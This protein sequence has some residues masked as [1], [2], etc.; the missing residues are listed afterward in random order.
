MGR[1]PNLFPDPETFNPDRSFK[2]DNHFAYIPFSA[3]PRNCIGQRFAMME[4]KSILSKVLRHYELDLADDSKQHPIL[5]AELILRPESII[6]FNFKP[7][8]Y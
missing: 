6:K 2:T 8:V 4:V 1:N 7:R 3:G 5:T